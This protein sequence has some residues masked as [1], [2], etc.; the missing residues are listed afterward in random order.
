M[1][2]DGTVFAGLLV[3]VSIRNPLYTVSESTREEL[4]GAAAN[5]RAAIY[6]KSQKKKILRLEE[7][8]GK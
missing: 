3:S 6:R 5:R 8:A 1:A 7:N 2:V 4:T